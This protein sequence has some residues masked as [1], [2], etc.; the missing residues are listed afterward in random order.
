MLPVAILAGGLATRLRPITETIPKALIEV[1]GEPF[2]S[3]QL[4]LLS[5]SG[6]EQAVLCVG[7]LGERIQEYAG[8][9]RRFG[10]HLD[11][12]F[13]G[14]QLLGTAG[15]IRHA[16][17]LLGEAFF[18]LYGDSYLPF[19]YAAA[20]ETFLRLEKQGLMTVSRNEGRWDAS[21][22]E[23]SEGRILAYD[24]VNRTPRMHHIDYGLGV[25]RRTA[26]NNGRPHDIAAVYQELL[27]AGE[28]AAYEASERFYEVGSFQGIRDLE[29]FLQTRSSMG[30]RRAIFLDRD[31]V[32]NEPVIRDGRPYP[33]AS[34]EGLKLVPD[35]V[36][37]LD[38]LKAAGFLLIV[39]T[40]QPDVARGSQNR[41]AVDAIHAAI[42]KVLPIDDFYVCW[43]DDAD[44]CLCRKP[45]PGLLIEAAAKHQVNLSASFLIGDRWRDI[46]A[47]AAAGC[48]TVFIDR[49][50][51]ERAPERAPD[52]RAESLATAVDWILTSLQAGQARKPE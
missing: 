39:V 15:A 16:L 28:L 42:Q 32:L 26:F 31:G 49:F 30:A 27:Q 44:G 1:G 12:S 21:N 48:H 6:V 23:F 29:E 24:K 22:V 7:Y 18:V 47:G 19:N 17:P 10:L 34:V 8:D 33:P 25:F 35:A 41:Q 11:Y 43:H 14:P 51:S 4:R 40:N 52:F 20:E 50:Y 37:T 3:H 45:K 36:S 5:Q 38:R 13:D 46:D 2:L 9:G